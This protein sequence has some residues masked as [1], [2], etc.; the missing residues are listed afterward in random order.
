MGKHLRNT[1]VF[2][3]PVACSICGIR[4]MLANSSPTKFVVLNSLF[5][6]SSFQKVTRIKTPNILFLFY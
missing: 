1:D 4:H 5:K 6:E 2:R 3:C